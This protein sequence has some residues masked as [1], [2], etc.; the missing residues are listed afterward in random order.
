MKF[1]SKPFKIKVVEPI[2]RTLCEQRPRASRVQHE[3]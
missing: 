1:P 2:R 3:R